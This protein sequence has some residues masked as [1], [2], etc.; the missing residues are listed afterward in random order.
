M[1]GASPAC[2]T[3]VARASTTPVFF[4]T[5]SDH[6][7]ESTSFSSISNSRFL[8][9][10][11]A[12]TPNGAS[13]WSTRISS[14]R[15]IASAETESVAAQSPIV[16]RSCRRTI[17]RVSASRGRSRSKILGRGGRSADTTHSR[18]AVARTEPSKASMAADA[19]AQS[20]R[21]IPSRVQ[22][23]CTRPKGTVP[24]AATVRSWDVTPTALRSTS[25]RWAVSRHHPLGCERCPTSSSSEARDR[26][27][28]G[29]SGFPL[30][31]MR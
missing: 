2:T 29:P 30:W 21:P 25:N 24:I 20:S 18:I 3:H 12:A 4:S 14:M 10:L 27:G 1:R 9:P 6:R 7:G 8:S 23:A 11:I 28:G 17:G 13:G 31:E 19:V 15:P 16:S 26:R 5:A 22:S